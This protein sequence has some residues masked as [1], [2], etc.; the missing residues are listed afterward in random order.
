VCGRRSNAGVPFVSPVLPIS[1]VAAPKAAEA[2]HDLDAHDVFGL[3]VAKLPLYPQAQRRSVADGKILAV[4]CVGKNGLLV[5]GV[6]E[7]DALI[8]ATASIQRLF[9]FVRAVEDGKACGGLQPDRTKEEPEGNTCPFADGAPALN[10]VMPGNLGSRGKPLE[11]REGEFTGM[12]DEA[13]NLQS[14]IGG[15]APSIA[16]ALAKISP[17]L[18]A[19]SRPD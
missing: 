1:A 15:R 18:L 16:E 4:H 11:V 13:I 9:E 6:D 10:A 2:V 19:R 12:H 7:V 5:K 8:V 14:P 17:I 3:L